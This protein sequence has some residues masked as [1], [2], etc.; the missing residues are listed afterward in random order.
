MT[1]ASCEAHISHEV[2]K[3]DGIVDAKASYKNGNAIIEFDKTK[4][5]AT[6]IENAINATGYKVTDK[7]EN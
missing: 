3:L 2:N 5:N 1:C 6:E 7:K 4:T